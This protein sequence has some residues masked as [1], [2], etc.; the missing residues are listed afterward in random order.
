MGITSARKKETNNI[1][2]YIPSILLTSSKF[3]LPPKKVKFLIN[4][5]IPKKNP[6]EWT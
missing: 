6:I 2:K 3:G 1:F 4:M 5:F